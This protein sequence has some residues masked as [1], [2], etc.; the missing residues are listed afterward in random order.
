M[1][2][3]I[4]I[5]P[6][7]LL[8]LNLFTFVDPVAAQTANVNDY[9]RGTYGELLFY[10]EIRPVGRY[11]LML[12]NELRYTDYSKRWDDSG[13]K[14]DLEADDYKRFIYLLDANF[15]ITDKVEIGTRLPLIWRKTRDFSDL[16]QVFEEFKKVG[17]GDLLLKVKIDPLGRE[18]TPLRLAITAG[19]KLS[20]GEYESDLKLPLGSGTTD[21]SL[22]GSMSYDLSSLRID[23]DV[24]YVITGTSALRVNEV[25]VDRNLG[26]VFFY[27]FAVVQEIVSRISWIVE[28]NGHQVFDSELDGGQVLN[29]GQNRFSMSPGIII[30]VPVVDISLEGGFTYDLLGNNALA[31]ITPL[32]R[33]RL[34]KLFSLFGGD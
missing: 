20:T 33:M 12:D 22:M 2:K 10:D 30:K 27:D 24:G 13:N 4:F 6:I 1:K 15:G 16:K 29:D 26:D 28:F 31:G 23:G 7:I 34:G 32:F 8:V 9:V 21:I 18:S 25:N 14:E 11:N 17:I 3:L 5:L 19:F